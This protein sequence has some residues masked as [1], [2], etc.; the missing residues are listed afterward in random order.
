MEMEVD[1]FVFTM[2]EPEE[3]PLNQKE[4]T[5]DSP[6]HPAIMADGTLILRIPVVLACEPT[7]SHVPDYQHILLLRFRQDK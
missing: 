3:K 7:Q 5:R 4:D 6:L 2:I 1:E